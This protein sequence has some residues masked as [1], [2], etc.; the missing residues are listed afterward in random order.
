VVCLRPL[1][2]DLAFW[3]SQR[4]DPAAEERRAAGARAVRLWPLEPV[5]RLGLGSVYA[6]AADFANG[7]VQLATAA[8]LSPDD[9]Q[10]WAAQGELY[11]RWGEIEPGRYAQAE[12]AYRQAL[13]LAPDVAT[14]HTS[15]GLVL[16]RQ[17]RLDEGVAELERAVD[18]DATDGVAYGHLADLYLALEQAAEAAWASQEAAR[19]SDK[20]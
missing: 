1:L 8:R 9:P 13:T 6:Q 14:I 3:R 2:A 17:E 18:L 10:V 4:G 11:A 19:W 7:E 16:A 15:L 12:A 20:R 5:Y